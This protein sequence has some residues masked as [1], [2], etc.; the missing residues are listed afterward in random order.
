VKKAQRRS[1]LEMLD[2]SRELSQAG[3]FSATCRVMVPRRALWRCLAELDMT[4]INRN[5]PKFVSDD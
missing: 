1:E 3:V 2:N 4:L 5:L